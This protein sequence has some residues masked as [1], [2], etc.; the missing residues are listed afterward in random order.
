MYFDDSSTAESFDPSQEPAVPQAKRVLDADTTNGSSNNGYA[1][2]VVP[3]VR[4]R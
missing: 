1:Q 2:A 4:F 3:A